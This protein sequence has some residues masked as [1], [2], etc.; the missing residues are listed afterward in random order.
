MRIKSLSLI[1]AL[2]LAA[3]AAMAEAPVD[4]VKLM[5]EAEWDWQ[6]DDLIMRNGVNALDDLRREAEGGPWATVGILRPSSGGPR[7]VYVDEDEGVTEVMLYEFTEGLEAADYAVYRPAIAPDP[8]ADGTM[9]VGPLGRFALFSAYGAGH[10]RQMLFG[11]DRYYN[12]ELPYEAGLSAGQVL[13]QPRP[14]GQIA[15]PDSAYAQALL[16]DWRGHPYCRVAP[17][18]AD[19]WSRMSGIAVVTP[20]SL[21]AA[22]GMVRVFPP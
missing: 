9:A 8:D 1:C 11:N 21:I 20:A 17:S 4:W 10:D 7:V 18:A 16:Q 14:L 13:G 3:P 19:C 2:L 6:P 15:A 5:A 22:R 12:A